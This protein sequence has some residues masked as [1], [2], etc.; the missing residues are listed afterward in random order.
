MNDTP[1]ELMM[2]AVRKLFPSMQADALK[3]FVVSAQ[4]NE[5]KLKTAE[6]KVDQLRETLKRAETTAQ[7]AQGKLSGLD[8]RIIAVAAREAAVAEREKKIT[9]LEIRKDCADDK[10]N[11]AER[12]FNSVF[13]NTIVRETKIGEVP[14]ET[15]MADG[16]CYSST[17][18][19]KL[20]HEK[21]SV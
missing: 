18:P 8:G 11:L 9:E 2:T 10:A 7:N 14:L 17:V 16:S 1:E 19:V 15:R 3:H 5:A 20:E 4:E 13:R 12:L 21:E 6:T